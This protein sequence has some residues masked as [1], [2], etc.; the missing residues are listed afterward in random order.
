MQPMVDGGWIDCTTKLEKQSDLQQSANW[1]HLPLTLSG[2]LIKL[3]SRELT[4]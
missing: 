1:K 3:I 4:I 2:E